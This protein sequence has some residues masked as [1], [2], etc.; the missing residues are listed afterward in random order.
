[1]DWGEWLS[2]YS[3]TRKDGLWLADGTVSCPDFT[4]HE[5]KSEESGRE[6]PSDDRVLLAAL[7]G[8][9]DAN[10]DAFLTI[11][12]AWSSPDGVR[13]TASSVLVPTG[14]ANVAARALATAPPGHLWL[15]TLE[16]YGEEDEDYRRDHPDMLPVE[17]WITDTRV[18]LTVDK[19]D[20]DGC[21]EAVQRARPSKRIIRGFKL[22]ADQPWAD[23]WR[24]PAQRAVF[25]SL[26]WG[27]ND[28][29]ET[30][31]FG[32]ALQCERTFLSELLSALSRHLIL[33]VNLQHYRERQP[34]E[35]MLSQNRTTILE[36]FLL[37][38]PE[39]QLAGFKERLDDPARH[40]KITDSDYSEREL[41]PQY[42]EAYEDAMAL[43]S[44]R[45]APW[46]IIPAN[47]K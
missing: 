38:S 47:H 31:E 24:D 27:R 30:Y 12:G 25:R 45:H 1:M 28:D 36:F 13:V 9:T 18:E 22:G 6:R 32:S 11:D 26:A 42:V 29:R 37:I 3:P 23:I 44:T 10:I 8:V 15:P 5:L 41:W 4:L 21:H 33:L 35:T 17:A 14:D 39:E 2:R 7:V 19:Y 43:T 34:F 46:Y 20:P 16:D 40:W